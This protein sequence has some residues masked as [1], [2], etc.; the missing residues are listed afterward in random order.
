MWSSFVALPCWSVTHL[1]AI[2][3]DRLPKSHGYLLDVPYVTLPGLALPTT[4]G[5]AMDAHAA[6]P[7]GV[8]AQLHRV[9]IHLRGAEG[10][11]PRLAGTYLSW[12]RRK[13]KKRE[14]GRE[15]GDSLVP[16]PDSPA[17]NPQS[18]PQATPEPVRALHLVPFRQ[19][20][21]TIPASA[22]I[23]VGLPLTTCD[24]DSRRASPRDQI[25]S[26]SPTCKE[27]EESRGRGRPAAFRLCNRSVFLLSCK[28]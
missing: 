18:N 25:A 22:R 12:R 17:Q 3:A 11:H 21:E 10:G 24:S 8:L 7:S 14:R 5:C 27:N 16:Q 2:D 9:P 20:K 13:R 26:R 15:D 6:L 4:T 1:V 28:P 23:N 19:V